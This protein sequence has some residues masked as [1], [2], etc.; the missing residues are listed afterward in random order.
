MQIPVTIIRHHKERLSKCSLESL[1]G[2][3][4]IHFIKTSS[5]LKFDCTNFILLTINAP[6]LSP[7]DANHPLLLL[8]STWKLL[9]NLETCLV[10][11][12]IRRSLPKS[13]KTAYPRTSKLTKDP[14]NG[15]ASIEALYIAKYILGQNDYSLLDAYYWK[16]AFLTINSLDSQLKKQ[17]S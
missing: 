1:N 8:D 12:P 7:A 16:E 4:E 5:N 2:R 10:G 6:V 3:P 13:F 14:L 17:L 9:P 11:T 15:L